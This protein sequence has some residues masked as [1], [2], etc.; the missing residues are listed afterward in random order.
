MS[1]GS[2]ARWVAARTSSERLWPALKSH[3]CQRQRAV[4]SP[5]RATRE[6][7]RKGDER[8]GRDRKCPAVWRS[9]DSRSESADSMKS[10]WTS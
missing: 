2:K 6:N 7:G 3:T 8:E 5:K 1:R 4:G 9:I 10:R